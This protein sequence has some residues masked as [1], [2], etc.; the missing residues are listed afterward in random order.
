MRIGARG[1]SSKLIPDY[2]QPSWPSGFPPVSR[3]SLWITWNIIALLPTEGLGELNWW[4]D[5]GSPSSKLTDL[6][7]P[8][9]MAYCASGFLISF[10]LF[11]VSRRLPAKL[12]S[13]LS[14][15]SGLS[16]TLLPLPPTPVQKIQGSHTVDAGSRGIWVTRQSQ[17]WPSDKSVEKPA[18]FS[19][20]CGGSCPYYKFTREN[21]WSQLSLSMHHDK[22]GP[23]QWTFWMFHKYD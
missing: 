11:W 7:Q 4:E 18:F 3:H 22:D 17:Q 8:E 9:I 1:W 2:L 16:L 6:L 14:Q 10:P 21:F 12:S 23:K 15:A 19:L 5:G 13:W 20:H